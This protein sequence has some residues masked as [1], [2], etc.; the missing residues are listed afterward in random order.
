MSSIINPNIE[1][2]DG[3]LMHMGFCIY[4]DA[5]MPEHLG[6][7]TE[8]HINIGGVRQVNAVGTIDWRTGIVQISKSKKPDSIYVH[9]RRYALIKAELSKV[10]QDKTKLQPLEAARKVLQ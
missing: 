1:K 10:I 7:F 4:Q 5:A 9:P 2:A 6:V 3:A 8:G